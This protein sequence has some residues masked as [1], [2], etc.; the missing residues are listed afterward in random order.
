[1]L[2]NV[3]NKNKTLIYFKGKIHSDLEQIHKRALEI[4]NTRKLEKEK[5]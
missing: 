2:T 5:Y 3:K 4:P 1:M